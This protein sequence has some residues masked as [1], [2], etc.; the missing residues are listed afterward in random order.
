M[1]KFHIVTLFPEFFNSPLNVGI[2]GRSIQR[3]LLKV[4]LIPLR[5]FATGIHQSVDDSPFSGGDGMVLQYEPL[6]QAIES[7]PKKS[8]VYYLSPKGKQWNYEMARQWAEQEQKARIIICGRYSGIDQR[9]IEEL[10]DEEISVGDYVLTGGEPAALLIL[11]SLCRFIKGALGNEYSATNESFEDH[12]LLECP[13]WTRPREIK[14][15]YIP[16]ILFSGHHQNI[17]KFHYFIS[18]LLTALKRPD[19]LAASSAKRDVPAALSYA[20]KL[21]D[22]ELIA[23]GLCRANLQRISSNKGKTLTKN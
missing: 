6:K 1:L 14:G 2:L 16:K 21:S 23:C 7:A 15:H 13:Q 18:V 17:K 9:V 8:T 10:V 5:N 12:G 11:D 20:Q 22:E 19:L 3:N 4:N